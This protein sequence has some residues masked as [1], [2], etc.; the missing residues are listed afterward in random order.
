MRRQPCSVLSCSTEYSSVT[1][2]CSTTVYGCRMLILTKLIVK[3]QLKNITT[4]L[5]H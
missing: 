1:R 2:I 5:L 3:D 4:Q